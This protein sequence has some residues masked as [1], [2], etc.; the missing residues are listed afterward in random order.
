MHVTNVSINYKTNIPA[1]LRALVQSIPLILS[2]CQI[3]LERKTAK[4]H[5]DSYNDIT[6]T[7]LNMLVL[8]A[9]LFFVT[10]ADSNNSLIGVVL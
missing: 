8:R 7:A 9:G 6:C 2:R 3:L 1:G 10:L 4:V 5:K